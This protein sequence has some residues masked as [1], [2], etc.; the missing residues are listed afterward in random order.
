[1]D[2]KSMQ[3]MMKLMA[4]MI[5]RQDQDMQSLKRNDSFILYFSKEPSGT[6]S[7][8]L[9]VAAQWK[10]QMDQPNAK[11]QLPLRSQLMIS[12]LNDL[13]TRVT[14]VS[15]SKPEDQLF[16]ATVNTKL[17]LEDYTW[18]Y[19]Q[20]CPKDQK[21]KLANKKAVAMQP[22]MDMCSELIEFFQN[23]QL[24]M[25][26]HAL[27][28]KPDS[29]IVPWRLQLNGRMDAPF[30]LLSHLCYCGVWGLL[31]TQLKP[32]LQQQSPLATALQGMM[33]KGKGKGKQNVTPKQPLS[34]A[35]P[36][37]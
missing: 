14:A 4:T 27:Q 3:A 22:M 33:G 16:Q 26:F 8:L 2:L 24:T 31:G 13:L 11:P 25:K 35:K 18:P 1:M 29:R 10:G 19:L 34:P 7:Q 36:E 21:Y 37:A 9:K 17:M 5:L 15:K 20:W 6:L 32:H 28:D 23:P 30:D 12:L